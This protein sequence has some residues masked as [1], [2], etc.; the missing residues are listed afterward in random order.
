MGALNPI[1]VFS[2]EVRSIQ[3]QV[4]AVMVTNCWRKFHWRLSYSTSSR[5]KNFKI[6]G[7]ILPPM[8]FFDVWG[9][10]IKDS[11]SRLKSYV[12]YLVNLWSIWNS[13]NLSF[14]SLS[15]LTG[16][17]PY[18]E[19]ERV[20]CHYGWTLS[21]KS[22]KEFLNNYMKSICKALKKMIT[23]FEFL[24]NFMSKSFLTTT[25]PLDFNIDRNN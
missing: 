11:I 16:S 18:F 22:L 2:I 12:L 7:Y 9:I 1:E 15:T 5:L 20:T 19:F 21:P 4:H 13:D 3:N 25:K 17:H 6:V 24:T 14:F 10:L 23:F 8:A